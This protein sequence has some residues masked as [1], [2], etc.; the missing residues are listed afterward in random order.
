MGIDC[1]Q[2]SRRSN[3]LLDNKLRLNRVCYIEFITNCGVKAES[4]T[5]YHN[6][7]LGNKDWVDFCM[8]CEQFGEVFKGSDNW[9]AEGF[10]INLDVPNN[11]LL[12]G[13][14]GL[15]MLFEFNLN[16]TVTAL[17]KEGLSLEE[18]FIISHDFVV[19][20]GF[21]ELNSCGGWHL[22]FGK[23][24]DVEKWLS[25]HIKRGPLYSKV[26]GMAFGDSTKSLGKQKPWFD[27]SQLQG[28]LDK[29]FN[30]HYYSSQ[31][32]PKELADKFKETF[33]HTKGQI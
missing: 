31:I 8:N 33:R 28:Y 2:I 22:P 18:I 24:P 23:T 27:V 19:R 17:K 13:L 30:I 7:N 10:E 32:T 6:P 14:A 4:L 20:E 25:N 21:V 3:Y 9:E 12:I 26:G 1:S 16:E 11:I 15:R 29:E 5:V